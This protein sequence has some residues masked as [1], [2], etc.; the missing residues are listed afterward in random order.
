[1]RRILSLLFMIIVGILIYNYFLG[2]EEEKQQAS[3]IFQTTKELALD[4]KELVSNERD[5]YDDGKYD[6]V[7]TK[8]RD[9][10]NKD[11]ELGDKYAQKL[12]E[13]E[14]IQG[15]LESEQ[16]KKKRKST[17]YDDIKEQELK[18]QLDALLKELSEDLEE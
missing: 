18:R 13:I 10:V 1:M 12:D 9:L 2:D 3:E 14:E 15:E 5:R 4:I 6:S 11:E 7:I 17:S 8:L 16:R